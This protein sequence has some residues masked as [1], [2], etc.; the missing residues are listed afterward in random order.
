MQKYEQANY[1]VVVVGGGLAGYSAAVAA[2]RGGARTCLVRTDQFSAAIVRVRFAITPHGAGC[3]HPYG[4]ETGIVGEVTYAERAAC[5]VTAMENAWTNSQ[6]DLALY[7]VACRTPNLT[8]HLNTSC[9]EVLL[10]ASD[11]DGEP[12]R[13]STL[14][15]TEQQVDDSRGYLRSPP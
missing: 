6:W 1:D 3:H 5:H 13:G 7:D 4:A 12:V 9:D 14:D 8:M 15:P 2:A 10:A 11:A